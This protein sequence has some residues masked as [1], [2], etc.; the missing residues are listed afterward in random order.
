MLGIWHWSLVPGEGD[1]RQETGTQ[2]GWY[3]G[4]RSES[5]AILWAFLKHPPEMAAALGLK[6]ALNLWLDAAQLKRRCSTVLPA[7]PHPRLVRRR[8]VCNI[9]HLAEAKKLR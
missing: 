7:S 8:K 5:T 1:L 4:A 6:L 2:Q 9:L 3:C